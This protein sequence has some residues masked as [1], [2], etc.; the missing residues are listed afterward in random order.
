MTEIPKERIKELLNFK[1]E[2]EDEP[3][4]EK[5][6]EELLAYKETMAGIA[7]MLG[8]T[9]YDITN[10]NEELLEVNLNNDVIKNA[11]DRYRSFEN[12]FLNKVTV[13]ALKELLE[14]RETGLT[15]DQVDQMSEEISY[16][17]DSYNDM[18]ERYN[19]MLYDM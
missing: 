8:V 1:K 10:K 2:Y 4:T 18:T 16:L 3:E 6:L 13:M 12:T 17:R 9:Q 19:E 7:R 14:Y 15:P 5:C 11:L